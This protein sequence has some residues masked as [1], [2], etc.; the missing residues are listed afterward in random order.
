MDYKRG[1]KRIANVVAI[2]VA[3]ACGVLAGSLAIQWRDDAREFSYG[4]ILDSLDEATKFLA[5]ENNMTPREI[6]HLA[7][8]HE[9]LPDGTSA[10]EEQVRLA[11]EYRDAGKSFWEKLSLYEMMGMIALCGL[12]GAVAGY[13]GTWVVLW[14]GGFPFIRWLVRGFADEKPATFTK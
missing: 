8:N 6:I 12:G 9:N 13:I 1:C 3:I 5:H 4:E 14:C 11:I 7:A 10:S 2:V